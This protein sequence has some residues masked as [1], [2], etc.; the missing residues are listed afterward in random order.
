M[1]GLHVE[2]W[3]GWDLRIERPSRDKSG[4]RSER[5]TVACQKWSGPLGLKWAA[6]MWE[7]GHV[8]AAC[9]EC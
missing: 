6:R 1:S 8:G 4:P 5:T 9:V 2:R 7:Y 3:C